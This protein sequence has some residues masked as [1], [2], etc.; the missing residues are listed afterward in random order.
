MILSSY[1]NYSPFRCSDILKKL[2]DINNTIIAIKSLGL[3]TV[4]VF[5]RILYVKLTKRWLFNTI[6]KKAVI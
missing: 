1:F 6:Y 2:L 3:V 5:I 4:I